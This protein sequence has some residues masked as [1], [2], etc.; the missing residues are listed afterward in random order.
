M[1]HP[2]AAP[3]AESSVLRCFAMRALPG[4]VALLMLA[5]P[6]M[7]AVRAWEDVVT[8]PTYLEGPADLKP[9][10]DAMTVNDYEANYPYANRTNLGKQRSMSEWRRL[11][12]DNDYLTCSFLPDLGGH[13]YTCVD[14]LS[15]RPMFH[16]NGSI[17]KGLIG[18]RGAWVSLGIEMNFPIGHT[19]VTVSP[20]DF[21][22]RREPGRAM[23]WVG[24]RDRVTGMEW[25]VEFVLREG[26]AMLE[27]NVSLSNQTAVR[28][29]YYW[30]NNAAIKLERDTRLVLP[31]N[32]VTVHGENRMDIWP[33]A[34]S[35]VDKGIDQSMV[36]NM[37]GALS[38]FAFGT[39]E[40]FF[41][42]YQGSSRTA[43]VH[44]A[45]PAA[46]PGKK[47]WAWGANDAEIRRQ[48][49]DDNSEY[50][51]IQAGVFSTQEELEFLGPFEERRFTEYWLPARNLDGITRANTSA[52]LYF[53]RGTT[54]GKSE[55][56]AELNVTRNINGARVR[57]LKDS[58][59]VWDRAEDLA[60]ARTLSHSIPDPAN[61]PY[62]FE[63]LDAK[64]TLLL[65]HTEG[66]YDADPASSVAV[67]PLPRTDC[68]HPAS[69]EAFVACNQD[70]E[71]NG[72]YYWAGA[73]YP[74]G[75]E[76]F[77]HSAAIQKAAGRLAVGQQRYA[78][79]VRMLEAAAASVP[80]D[81]EV[82]Y[83]LG[84]AQAA[85]GQD[86]AARAAWQRI[87]ADTAFGMAARVE[88]A[89]SLARGGKIEDAL[90]ELR[91]ARALPSFPLR[92]GRMEVALL[93]AA[94]GNDE[95]RERLNYWLAISP[96]DSFLEWERV[97]G[98]PGEALERHLAADPERVLDIVDQYLSLGLYKD[99]LAALD[100]AWPAVPANETEPGAVLP[101]NY[102][103]VAY[104]RGYCRQKAGADGSADFKL[105]AGLPLERV[106]PSRASSFPVLEA[107]LATNLSDASA[108]WLLGLLQMNADMP[109]EA[110]AE[111]QKARA[112]RH[113]IPELYPL[114]SQALRDM[115][116]DKAAALAV[117]A[118]A[119]KPPTAAP[120]P[121][122][123]SP[124]PKTESP[125]GSEAVLPDVP[126]NG[127]V[128]ATATSPRD[129]AGTALMEVARGNLGSG[130]SLFTAHNFPQEKQPADVRKAYIEV[131]L[132]ALRAD[133][134]NRHCELVETGF[135]TIGAE[136]KGL[137]FTMYGFEAFMKEPRFQYYLADLEAACGER[138]TARKRWTK[139]AKDNPEETGAS[140]TEDFPFPS[141]AA[142]R[143]DPAEA[144]TRLQ[145]AESAVE[146]RL[147]AAEPENRG[148]WLY[149]QGMLLMALGQRE[150][151]V[152]AFEQGA[153]AM[154]RGESQYLN[155]LAL[156]EA[157]GR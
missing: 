116:G 52:V 64:G 107:A 120:A 110:I 3:G 58:A 124:A 54:Q 148:L 72:H 139:L 6:A 62:R 133:V 11:V 43:T 39:R 138:K 63:L 129:V 141:L 19:R 66:V 22:W 27:Q 146:K 93:R 104:Y 88:T 76:Q 84:L 114:L 35:G 71:R 96:I 134:A 67:G 99:A 10:L 105:A 18:L 80:G 140:P 137:T 143:L 83:Y 106:F 17:K 100:R 91:Q 48:L 46:V 132:Q 50:I 97:P 142:A 51:E 42:A 128:S 112:L 150:N 47:L 70:N 33:V 32:L 7:G 29:P 9:A 87:T 4:F 74:R 118:E 13:L 117:M 77:P 115:K 59:T 49:S 55:L 60:P 79:A 15:G 145:A 65:A 130:K 61:G 90:E 109:D 12:I 92:A 119:P 127:P 73:N 121:N 153:K 81:A 16:A 69:A 147:A 24:A 151:A 75:L 36:S 45:D 89:A 144:K 53:G 135:E 38:V 31:A 14:K 2:A 157:G 37:K 21:A 103:L 155:L 111:W 85:L 82:T 86:D 113:D 108:H 30:W 102:A 149:S 23:V 78:E 154:D 94:G 40:P 131:Q 8:L 25:R 123:E 98:Q 125:P 57:I 152:A 5:A 122:I 26:A 68:A 41:G 101:Q 95:A 1:R 136:D 56:T 156:R 28:H 44:V 126:V 34:T 20:V